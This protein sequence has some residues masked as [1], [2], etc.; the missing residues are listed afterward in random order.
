[1]QIKRVNKRKT[2]RDVL[3]LLGERILHDGCLTMKWKEKELDVKAMD[4][5]DCPTPRLSQ[6]VLLLLL[7]VASSFCDG[8]WLSDLSFS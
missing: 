2:D 8:K 7:S 1:M 6:D 4:G 5:S 3:S